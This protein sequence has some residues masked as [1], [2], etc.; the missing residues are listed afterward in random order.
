MMKQ[1]YH[2]YYMFL[3]VKTTMF[4]PLGHEDD[5]YQANADDRNQNN[6]GDVG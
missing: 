2:S 5:G 3:F 6:S 4:A 1:T